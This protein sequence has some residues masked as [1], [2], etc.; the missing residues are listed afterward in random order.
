[1]A[2]AP[3]L[4]KSGKVSQNPTGETVSSSGSSTI[5]VKNTSGATSNPGDCGYIEN[6]EYKIGTA[7]NPSQRV[8]VTT[9]GANNANIEVQNRENVTADYTGSAPAAQD[10]LKYDGVGALVVDTGYTPD[11]IAVATAAGSG[12]SVDVLMVTGRPTELITSPNNFLFVNGASG[13]DFLTTISSIPT[14]T[15]LVYNAP[16][17]GDE[18][19]IVPQSSSEL[20]KI[21]L[22]NTTRGDDILIGSVNTSTNTITLATGTVPGSWAISDTITTRS[23]TNTSVFQGSSRWFDLEITSTEIP[24]SAIGITLGMVF[25]DTASSP[26]PFALHPFESSA[27]SKQFLLRTQD[28]NEEFRAVSPVMPVINKRLQAAW[29]AGGTGTALIELR[30]FGVVLAST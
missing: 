17:S 26:L 21:V 11:T 29:N 1:M 5:A 15:T 23:Q 25:N 20:A 14:T 3:T 18:N 13:S 30:V 4:R 2:Q 19:S 28:T 22:H 16:S 8:I 12:G 9:G 24:D 27:N 10:P 7:G 6:G